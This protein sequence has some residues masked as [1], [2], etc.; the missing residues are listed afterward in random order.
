[1]KT[2]KLWD[3]IR[4]TTTDASEIFETLSELWDAIHIEDK[5]AQ[6]EIIRQLYCFG[7][8]DLSAAYGQMV[9]LTVYIKKEDNR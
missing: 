6:T 4:V 7:K 1:M 8:V 3:G 5:E 9:I 2:V